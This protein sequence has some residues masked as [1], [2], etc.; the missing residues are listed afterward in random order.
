LINPQVE[1][2]G[3]GTMSLERPSLNIA[4]EAVLSAQASART[5]KGKTVTFFKDSQGRIVV[6]LRITGP[7]ESAS[8]ELD[9]SKILQ[10][11][12]GQAAEKGLGTFFKQLFR[13]R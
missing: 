10:Q 8:V 2:K 7:V 11:G 4:M 13:K 1:M 3:S 6:P 12:S 9:S 5:G